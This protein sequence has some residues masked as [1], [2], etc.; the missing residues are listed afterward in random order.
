MTAAPVR[1]A[2]TATTGVFH[3]P[4][5]RLRSRIS[6]SGTVGEPGG[7]LPSPLPSSSDFFSAFGIS[8]RW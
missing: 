7:Y 4:R 6:P 1:A 2:T 3:R 5:P 8:I